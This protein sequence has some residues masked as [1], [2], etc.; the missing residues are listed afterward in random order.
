MEV[1]ASL[2]KWQ[3]MY[4]KVISFVFEHGHARIPISTPDQKQMN[5]W[6]HGQKQR[7]KFKGD[8]LEKICVIKNMIDP[9]ERDKKAKHDKASER[10]FCKLQEHKNL[11]GSLHSYQP[12][13]KLKM[14]ITEQRPVTTHAHIASSFY[15]LRHPAWAIHTHLRAPT[16]TATSVP[17]TICTRMTY[18]VGW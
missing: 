8:Q 10:M 1:N 4:D 15:T 3:T 2:T 17:H 12:N 6:G 14:W 16:D 11:T 7:K 18:H 13:N 9:D 5:E